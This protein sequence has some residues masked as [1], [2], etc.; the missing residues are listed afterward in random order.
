MKRLIVA[1]MVFGALFAIAWGAAAA[2]NVTGGALQQGSANAECDP[3]GVTVGYKLD[4]ANVDW[5][6]ITDVGDDNGDDVYDGCLGADLSVQLFT[7][8][9]TVCGE[10]ETYIDVF[11]AN[12][13]HDGALAGGFGDHDEAGPGGA[14]D[15]DPASTNHAGGGHYDLK[16]DGTCAIA[17]VTSVQVTIN[18]DAPPAEY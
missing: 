18:D 4:G 2:L 6:H 17:D 8:T 16:P 10:E 5:V 1:L 14:T 3:D 7:D 9:T 11:A 13:N 15:P 12:T